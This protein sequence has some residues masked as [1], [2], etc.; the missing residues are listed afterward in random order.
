[1]T[2]GAPLHREFREQI[3]AY[4]LGQLSGERRRAVHEHLAVC[5]A[6]RAE[7]DEIA[8]VAGLLGVARERLRP[9]D[10]ATGPADEVPPLSPALL[11]EI[12]ADAG[13]GRPAP[14]AVPGGADVVAP[15]SR[16]RRLLPLAAAAVAVAL[17]AGVA[18]YTVGTGPD[19]PREPIT[20]RALDPAVRA[21]ANV[22]DHTWGMEVDLTA[23]GFRMGEAYTVTVTDDAGRTVGAG[24]F[25][26]TG[27]AQMRCNLNSSVM[28]VDASTVQVRGADGRV[29]L[30]AVV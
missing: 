11:A 5:A 17:A 7:L 21:S 20:V 8:P 24:E 25:I 4:A 13:S 10:L 28:R 27:A 6:C 18:G 9:E 15:P 26:G 14:G 23:T 1:M 29:V 12:R 3:G 2:G 22:I 16:T 19:V 30:D